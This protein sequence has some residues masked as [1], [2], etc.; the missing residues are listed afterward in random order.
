MTSAAFPPDGV[1]EVFAAVGE[2]VSLSCYNASL[3][4]VGGAVQWALGGRTL[5]DEVSLFKG[6]T[7]TLSPLVIGTAS[8][9][10]AGDYQCTESTAQQ[11]VLNKI[12]LHTVDSECE[13]YTHRYWW[14]QR[15]VGI[16]G[17][18]TKNNVAKITFFDAP[19][20]DKI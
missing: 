13:N 17:A 16:V 2:T 5:P 20:V 11:K 15:G 18:D 9:E 6:Q 10:H 1:E 3:V 12:R 4:G 8:A 7:G 19:V 14:A